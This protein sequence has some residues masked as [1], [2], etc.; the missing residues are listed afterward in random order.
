MQASDKT[1]LSRNYKGKAVLAITLVLL[2]FSTW[3]RQLNSLGS[4]YFF[5]EMVM[6]LDTIENNI[7][8][9]M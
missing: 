7:V 6:K 2:L 8:L 4:S 3:L 5:I 1:L 9:E